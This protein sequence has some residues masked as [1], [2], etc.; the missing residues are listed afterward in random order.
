MIETRARVVE[1]GEG[2]ALVEAERQAG[3]GHCDSSRGCGKSAMSKLF[4]VKSRTFEVIDPIGKKV[5]DEVWIGV[6][7]GALLRS[8]LAVYGV[9]MGALLAGS[10]LGNA[11]GDMGAVLGGLAGLV[12]GFFWARRY[13][14][15]N[16]GNKRFQPYI[17]K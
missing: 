5:G 11:Y 4:S 1:A 2:V 15:A 17:L 14:A 10:V 16:R 13:S 3:C 7:D 12:M 9:P 8:C 6:Q